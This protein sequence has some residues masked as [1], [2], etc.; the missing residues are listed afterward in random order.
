VAPRAVSE[1]TRTKRLTLDLSP[2]L[3]RALKIRAVDL[4]VPMAQLL[5]AL[6]EK[7]LGNPSTLSRLA[8]NLRTK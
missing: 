2:E 5:R 1:D 4:D 3:H 6:I 7:A 8:N